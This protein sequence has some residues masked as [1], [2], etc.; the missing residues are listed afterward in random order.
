MFAQGNKKTENSFYM[1]VLKYDSMVQRTVRNGD[2]LFASM[3]SASRKQYEMQ[4]SWELELNLEC[5][6]ELSRRKTKQQS[7]AKHADP[8]KLV[9]IMLSVRRIMEQSTAFETV[10]FSIFSAKMHG[11]I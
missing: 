11:K 5:Y 3:R 2:S 1:R 10:T 9:G 7:F 4:L 6:W 8:L